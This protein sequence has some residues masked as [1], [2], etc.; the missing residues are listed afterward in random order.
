MKKNKWGIKMDEIEIGFKKIERAVGYELPKMFKDLYKENNLKINNIS[1]L[2]LD[3]IINDIYLAQDCEDTENDN[4][5]KV[6]PNGAI[7]KRINTSKR[8]PFITDYSGNYIGIDYMPG[9][10]GNVGQIINYGRDELQM[11]VFANSFKRF[12]EGLQKIECKEE[13]YITD[14]LLNNNVDFVNENDNIEILE[15]IVPLKLKK[16]EV[17]EQIVNEKTTAITTIDNDLID[18]LINTLNT[19]NVKIKRDVNVLKFVEINDEYRIKN[20]RDS[21]SRTMI[22]KQNFYEKLKEYPKE[23]IKGYSF[24]KLMQVEEQIDDKNSKVGNESLFI[25]IDL[26]GNVLVRYRE[27]V[28]TKAFREIYE[29]ICKILNIE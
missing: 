11:K 15:K 8:V 21:L 3:E 5:L 2:T 22:G 10:K 6:I 7:K 1:L 23:E 20:H 14:Y 28:N 24:C 17:S 9:N 29:Q 4:S 13:E 16:N 19:I 27:T 18:N 25:D 26:N 12:I